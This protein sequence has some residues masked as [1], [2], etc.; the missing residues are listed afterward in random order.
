MKECENRYEFISLL[1]VG[2][3]RGYSEGSQM[4]V[5]YWFETLPQFCSARGSFPISWD[6]FSGK[7]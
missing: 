7:V 4:Y 6:D 1:L 2:M 3:G 5:S